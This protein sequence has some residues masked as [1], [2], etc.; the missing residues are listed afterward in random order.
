[1]YRYY[2]T[3]YLQYE[4]P[5]TVVYDIQTRFEAETLDVRYNTYVNIVK[6]LSINGHKHLYS[7]K[8]LKIGMILVE[9]CI[10]YTTTD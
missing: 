6:Y 4:W 5:Y 1:M 8:I 10:R 3:Y 9:F 7:S 2:M